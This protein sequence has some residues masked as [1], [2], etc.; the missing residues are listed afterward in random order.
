MT[1]QIQEDSGMGKRKGTGSKRSKRRRPA[2][3]IA[4]ASGE[5]LKSW[6]VGALP[7]VNRV[8][9]RLKLEE[10]L[11]DGLP[12]EDRRVKVPTASALLVLLRNLL[13]SREPLYGIGEWAAGHAPDLLG[14]TPEQLAALNDDRVGRCLDRLFDCD[15]ASLA[16]AV[17]GHAVRQFGVSLDELHNDSTT[18]TFH[19]DYR[20]ALE[21]R[22]LR[23]R[24]RLAITWG[25]NKDHRPDLK[26][27]LYILTIARDGGVPVQFRVASGNVADDQT[28]Q[29]TW[30]LL[31]NLSGRRDFLYVADCKL[32]SAENMAYLHHRGGRFVTVLP[33]TRAEDGTFR[34]SLAAGQ[35]SWQPIWDKADDEGRL[36]DRFSVWQ[37]AS[38]SADGYR[39]LWYLSTRKAELDALA[40][41]GRI[42]RALKELAA[43]R[44]KLH[45]PRTR[46]RAE[47]KVA[48]AV[49]AI[50]AECQVT[51]WI[52]TEIVP[53]VEESYRQDRRGRPG[54]DTRYR[55]QVR[56]RF[57]LNWTIDHAQLAVERLG[58]GVFPLITNVLDLSEREVLWA[59]KRQPVIEK[60]FSQ[61][62]TDFAVAPVYLKEASRIQ[63]LLCVYFFALLVEALLE[64]QLRQA[65]QRANIE[66]LPMY[67]EGRPCRHPTTRRLIDLFEGIQRH[68]L[69]SARRRPRAFV[70][71][72]SPLQRRI[73]KLL[74]QP[75]TTYGH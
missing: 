70:T 8:L 31:C 73:L 66:S 15:T 52:A 42:Q 18:I 68:T 4:R 16:L 41:N 28:H 32:A 30:D 40:R 26:Q 71:D 17:V 65:M 62:K 44:E 34:R 55:K 2:G 74:A 64:R 14:L 58:D 39:L 47:A 37:P 67:P 46:Y 72:L 43:L 25:H 53:R 9:Q 38:Q 24:L 13:L 36:V 23:G 22:S 7:I 63:A 61:L 5:T 35:S 56:T 10:F 59:Y 54:K 6:S 57:D 27:L 19:G 20:S 60:R 11:R 29:D 1:I 45:S 49:E 3:R 48:E 51:E 69:L 75:R 21:E 50:L 12:A 33:R